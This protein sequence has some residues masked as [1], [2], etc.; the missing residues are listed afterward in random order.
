MLAAIVVLLTSESS[1]D[2]LIGVGIGGGSGLVNV[3]YSIF[4]AEPRK[5]VKE[6]VDH[7]TSTKLVFSGK[8]SA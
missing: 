6:G 3:L 2:N 4:M 7:I 5:K 8:W 1:T